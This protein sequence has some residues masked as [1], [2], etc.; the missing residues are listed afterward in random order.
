ML[1]PSGI[2]P[3]AFHLLPA[4]HAVQIQS[5][6]AFSTF[7]QHKVASIEGSGAANDASQEIAS[8]RLAITQ[9]QQLETNYVVSFKR[10]VPFSVSPWTWDSQTAVVS[11]QACVTMSKN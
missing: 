8:S 5:E 1:L 2:H 3:A 10:V 9:N 11:K 7:R 4:V 6:F